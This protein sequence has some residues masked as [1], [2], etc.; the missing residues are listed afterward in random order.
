MNK[1]DH[2]IGFRE[3]RQFFRAEN[4][5]K[6]QKIVII[7]STPWKPSATF[8]ISQVLGNLAGIVVAYRKDAGRIYRYTRTESDTKRFLPRRNYFVSLEFNRHWNIS[9]QSRQDWPVCGRFLGTF[10]G[11]NIF[12]KVGTCKKLTP[13]MLGTFRGQNIFTK[14]G[15]CKRL[16]PE[17]QALKLANAQRPCFVCNLRPVFLN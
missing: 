16:T 4:C 17:M 12:T 10:Q 2:N 6:S 14:V 3:K 1:F 15:T 13:E 7:T 5:R 11:Q 9:S 8:N